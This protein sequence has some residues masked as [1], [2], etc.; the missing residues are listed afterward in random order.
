M[1]ALDEMDRGSKTQQQQLGEETGNLEQF[2][3]EPAPTA[4]QED[5]REQEHSKVREAI[6]DADDLLLR[7]FTGVVASNSNWVV[8]G[9]PTLLALLVYGLGLGL[10]ANFLPKTRSHGADWRTA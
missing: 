10:L 6:D 4:D 1:F 8:R 9:V 5:L 3:V 2:A 7:P